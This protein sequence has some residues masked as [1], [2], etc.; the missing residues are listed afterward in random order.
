MIRRGNEPSLLIARDRAQG[1]TMDEM[2]LKLGEVGTKR[3]EEGDR[4]FMS[5]GAK[6]CTALGDMVY[7]SIVDNRYYKVRLTTKVQLIPLENGK[8][9]NDQ[10]RS[11]TNIEKGN[12]TV[13][14]L[15]IQNHRVPL[16]DTIAR[17]LSWH[18]ALRDILDESS[19]TE[20]MI[21]NLNKSEKPKRIIYHMPEGDLVCDESFSV[22]GYSGATARLKIWRSTIILEDSGDRFRKSGLVIKGRRAIHECSLLQPSFEKDEYAKRYFG[23]IECDY[24]DTLLNDYDNKREKGEEHS[25]E[26]P[27]LLIDP[28]R[29][30]GLERKHPFTKALLDVPTQKLKEFIDK[31]RASELKNVREI[32]NLETKNKLNELAKAASKFLKQQIENLEEI[33]AKRTHIYEKNSYFLRQEVIELQ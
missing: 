33:T 13:V 6:D 12:G 32:T 7:E 24:I 11:I 3:S 2:L 31:D 19:V 28:N 16:I 26:N 23:R 4:G 5:R 17:D 1:M 21:R 20:V 9:V 8:R 22:Q 18:F 27:I 30:Y 29:Q 10:I 14:T 25:I 15:E